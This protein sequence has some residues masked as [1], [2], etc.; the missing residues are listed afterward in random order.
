VAPDLAAESAEHAL[1]E[2][3]IAFSQPCPFDSWP[4][5][6]TTVLAGREDRFFPLE[7]QRRV[8]RERLGLD[9]VEL[10]GGHLTALSEPEAVAGAMLDFEAGA[11]R[12]AARAGTT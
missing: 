9:V 5:V 4:D 1:D 6:P 2:A 11:D 7:F 12:P 8:A 3:D 10:P